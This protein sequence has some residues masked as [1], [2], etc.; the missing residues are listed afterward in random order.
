TAPRTFL[1]IAQTPAELRGA[2][3]LMGVYSVLRIDDG[4][5]SFSEFRPDATAP[6]MSPDDVTP[7]NDDYA[8][9]YDQY[10]GQGSWQNANMSPD[11][12]SVAVALQNLWTASGRGERDG[13]FLTDPFALRQMLAATGPV[14]AG[15]LGTTL[16]RN[17]V[18]SFVT[19]EVSS[20]F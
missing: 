17:N 12:P 10:G 1:C 18:V 13:V 4:K 6:S 8:R 9:I 5:L 14:T 15:S 7:P 2:G 16:T 3:G 20:R 11:L 19:N